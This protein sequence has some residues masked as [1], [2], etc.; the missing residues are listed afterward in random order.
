MK[1][2]IY[3]LCCS[4]FL[5]A[6]SFHNSYPANWAPLQLSSSIECPNIAG[7]YINKGEGDN[8]KYEPELS[9][10]LFR[11]SAPWKEA[12]HISF[13]QNDNKLLNIT[14]WNEEKRIFNKQLNNTSNE[15]ICEEGLLKIKTREYLNREG[16]LGTE[17]SVLGLVRSENYLVVKNESGAI[18]M[19]FIVPVA[20]SGTNWYRFKTK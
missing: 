9:W 4:L 13:E 2:K 16:V 10:H 7:T 8:P 18:G 12:T 1:Y 5:S 11:N 15:F 6:C 3:I 14:L 17:W 19:M 20:G